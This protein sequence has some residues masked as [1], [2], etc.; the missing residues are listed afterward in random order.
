MDCPDSKVLQ[1]KIIS[2]RIC[3][4]IG[5]LGPAEPCPSP[6]IE[7][8]MI[9]NVP[10]SETE[11]EFLDFRFQVVKVTSDIEQAKLHRIEK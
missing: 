3:W 2:R 5:C 1:T 7:S 4:T 11:F 10:M 6:V 9:I 8:I